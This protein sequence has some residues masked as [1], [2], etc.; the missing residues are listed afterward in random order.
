MSIELMDNKEIYKEIYKTFPSLGSMA[1]LSSRDQAILL[2]FLENSMDLSE[3]KD[4]CITSQKFFFE[5]KNEVLMFKPYIKKS[6]DKMLSYMQLYASSL[7]RMIVSQSENKLIVSHKL[8]TE[9]IFSY[10]YQN[11][12]KMLWTSLIHEY[13]IKLKEYLL[14][15]IMHFPE[16]F[17]NF[18]VLFLTE[19]FNHEILLKD[20]GVDLSVNFNLTKD[21]IVKECIIYKENSENERLAIE[22]PRIFKIKNLRD[23]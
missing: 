22:S 13:L 15:P 5:E 12:I 10:E 8:I 3:I 16:F 23:C 9:N 20:Y 11:M 6:F 21:L 19:C 4:L 1:Q 18:A 7:N 17:R 2:T 14:N